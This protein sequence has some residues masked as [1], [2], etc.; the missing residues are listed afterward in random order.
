MDGRSDYSILCQ[1][2]HNWHPDL[3]IPVFV[4]RLSEIAN[5]LED[6]SECQSLG[7]YTEPLRE[8][9]SHRTIRLN[10]LFRR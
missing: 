8:E 4:Q 6:I 7:K 1:A 3:Y 10:I 2:P 9:S 5:C